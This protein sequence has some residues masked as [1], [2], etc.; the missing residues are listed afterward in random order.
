[1][2][3]DLKAQAQ[4]TFNGTGLMFFII[5]LAIFALLLF[6]EAVEMVASF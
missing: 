6:D 1:M 3:T 2:A 5:C 4:N